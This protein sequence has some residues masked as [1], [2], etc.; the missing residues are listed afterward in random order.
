V[1]D[2]GAHPDDP[3]VPENPEAQFVV[4]VRPHGVFAN[5][6]RYIHKMKPV[7][8]SRFVPKPG[9]TTPVPGWNKGDWVADTLPAG[10]PARDNSSEVIDR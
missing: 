3:L 9:C 4:R 6:P 10:D 1:P 8:R 7:P 2:I 5:I